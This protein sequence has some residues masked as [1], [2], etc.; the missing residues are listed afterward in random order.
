MLCYLAMTA[1]DPTQGHAKR[2]QSTQCYPTTQLCTICD[3]NHRP[4]CHHGPLKQSRTTQCKTPRRLE[5]RGLMT[6]TPRDPKQSRCR[7][8]SSISLYSPLYLGRSRL[9]VRQQATVIKPFPL[10]QI[11]S[12]PESLQDGIFLCR[13]YE[14]KGIVSYLLLRRPSE[15]LILPRQSDSTVS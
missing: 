11:P 15:M 12:Q 8:L 1:S 3:R 5:N 10:H 9:I 4:A 13:P 14:R 2:C 7:Y 6:Y